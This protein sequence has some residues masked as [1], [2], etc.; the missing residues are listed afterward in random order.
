[1]SQLSSVEFNRRGI[2]VRPLLY[3]SYHERAKVQF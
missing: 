3:V 2:S 1:M